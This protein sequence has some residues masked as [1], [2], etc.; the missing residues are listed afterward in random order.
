MKNQMTRYSYYFEMENLCKDCAKAWEVVDGSPKS[1][2]ADIYYRAA[3]GFEKKIKYLTVDES[4][5]PLSDERYNRLED[6]RWF[7]RNKQ[8]AAKRILEQQKAEGENKDSAGA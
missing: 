8:D 6:F 5:Q 3:E 4:C 2:T 7:V 1:V